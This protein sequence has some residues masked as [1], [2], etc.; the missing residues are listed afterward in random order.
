MRPLAVLDR[1][2]DDRDP[3]RVQQLAQLPEIVAGFERGDAER[4]LLGTSCSRFAASRGLADAALSRSLHGTQSSGL[5]MALRAR[6]QPDSRRPGTL[7]RA[8]ATT[9]ATNGARVL[10]R[11]VR[12]VQRHDGDIVAQAIDR[13]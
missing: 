5:R 12:P 4:P 2:A 13:R 10:G 7:V 3:G 1:L 11:R 8:A 6:G 9:F